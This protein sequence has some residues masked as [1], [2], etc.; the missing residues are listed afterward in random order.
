MWASTGVSAERDRLIAYVVAERNK[1]IAER[2]DKD[3]IPHKK[4]SE[5]IGQPYPSG[6]YSNVVFKARKRLREDPYN[7]HFASRHREGYVISDA[8][9]VLDA[10]GDGVNSTEK[11]LKVLEDISK[12]AKDEDLPLPIQ[13]LEWNVHRTK[14]SVARTFL[15]RKSHKEI[16]ALVAEE[17]AKVDP[18]D[19]IRLFANPKDFREKKRNGEEQSGQK[20]NEE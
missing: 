1:P 4:I 14:I 15:N 20:G 9:I 3:C 10:M 7:I 17:Q 8:L 5:I 2:E 13:K 6:R 12:C 16:V 11:H 19:L 18:G